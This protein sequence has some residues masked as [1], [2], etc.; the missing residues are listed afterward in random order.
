[1]RMEV[2]L[3]AIRVVLEREGATATAGDAERG[4]ARPRFTGRE[5][6]RRRHG[7]DETNIVR[8]EAEGQAAGAYLERVSHEQLIHEQFS[9]QASTFGAVPSHSA[10]ASLAELVELCAPRVSDQALD[11]A[12]GPGIVTCRVARH[13]K[14]IRGQDLVPA[15][16][17][18][19][20]ARGTELGLSNVG[21]DAGDSNALPYADGSFDLVLTRFSFHHLVEPLRT[22]REMRRVCKDGGRV[23]VAD[24]APSVETNERYD[25]FERIRD[26]SHTHA[27]NEPELLGLFAT[28][29]LAVVRTARHGLT[30]PL[31]TQL[32]ASFPAPGGA[33]ELRRLFR[34]DLGV[35]ALG[36]D[37][38]LEAGEIAFSYPVLIVAAEKR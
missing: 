37:A 14:S 18:R 1:M 8:L 19:A 2:V 5:A 13:V 33:D 22:L 35:N 28:A 27:L 32:A 34:A 3:E 36:V 26:P 7:P 6:S 4:E 9:R 23:V 31:E 17:D 30:M 15:M 38:R 29:G 10:E 12:C 24:V 25:H 11:L 21:W 16:L 20:R